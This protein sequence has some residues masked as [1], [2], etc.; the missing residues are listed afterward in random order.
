MSLLACT[1]TSVRQGVVVCVG[2]SDLHLLV[3]LYELLLKL[4]SV[5]ALLLLPAA[6]AAA[7]VRLLL[8][9]AGVVMA[10]ALLMFIITDAH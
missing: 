3:T 6:A 8:S 10:T 4:E 5:T 7:L 2:T 9:S 1:L